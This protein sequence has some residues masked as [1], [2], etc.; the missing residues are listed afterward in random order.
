MVVPISLLFERQLPCRDGSAAISLFAQQLSQ[1][2]GLQ[3]HQRQRDRY[4]III[5]E[6]WY[7]YY[8]WSHWRL[9]MS[10]LHNELLKRK[11]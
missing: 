9:P 8:L 1:D 6:V 4:C 2:G 10:E 3:S 11:L 5:G 7:W